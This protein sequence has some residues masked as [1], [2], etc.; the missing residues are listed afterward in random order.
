[1]GGRSVFTERQKLPAQRSG[2][3]PIL[4]FPSRQGRGRDI[5][6]AFCRQGL[7]PTISHNSQDM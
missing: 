4:A 7:K 2:S 3:A 1:M 5:E 6:V